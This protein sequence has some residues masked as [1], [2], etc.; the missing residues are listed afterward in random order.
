MTLSFIEEKK[1][2]KNN[3]RTQ[4]QKQQNN[5]N[6]N[7]WSVPWY[8]QRPVKMAPW[9]P[10][11]AS[12]PYAQVPTDDRD[13]HQHHEVRMHRVSELLFHTS[14]STHEREEKSKCNRLN[15]TIPLKLLLFFFQNMLEEQDSDL[16]V[17]GQGISRIGQLAF[18]LNNEILAQNK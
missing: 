12:S 9:S 8:F 6:F 15:F 16:D 7:K 3:S 18:G 14:V 10:P 2:E 11:Y 1:L 5:N 17:L 13:D 4:Q